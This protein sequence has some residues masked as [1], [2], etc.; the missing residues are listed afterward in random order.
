MKNQKGQSLVEVTVA[1]GILVLVFSSVVILAANALN[2]MLDSRDKTEG[3]AFAQKYLEKTKGDKT[4]TCTALTVGTDINYPDTA[5]GKNFTT[6]LRIDSSTY[7]DMV[8]VTATTT[9]AA[10]NGT[11]RNVTAKQLVSTKQW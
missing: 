4:V 9:W 3:V 8:L 6:N 7:T 11:E 10:K 1:L 2:L 5:G